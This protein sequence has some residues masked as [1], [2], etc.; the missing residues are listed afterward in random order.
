MRATLLSAKYSLYFRTSLLVQCILYL[1]TRCT[2]LL[3][4]ELYMKCIEYLIF[5]QM[6]PMEREMGSKWRQIDWK[7]VFSG[8]S[9]AGR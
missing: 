1:V 4:E 5:M 6:E 3:Y 9:T 7:K 2:I 8:E